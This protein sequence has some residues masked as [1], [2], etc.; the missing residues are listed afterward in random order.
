MLIGSHR[1]LNF[2]NVVERCSFAGTKLV[3]LEAILED[4]W[5]VS[6]HN[7]DEE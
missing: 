7:D 2:S 3:S 4:G 6:G 1:S 5:K